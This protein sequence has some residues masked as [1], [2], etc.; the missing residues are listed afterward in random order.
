MLMLNLMPAKCFKKV[1]TRA[2]RLE[3]LYCELCK[4]ILWKI[5]QLHWQQIAIT[6]GQ[7]QKL[8]VIIFGPLPGAA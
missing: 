2:K 1:G 7:G 3:K 6:K 5:S 4:R 8:M